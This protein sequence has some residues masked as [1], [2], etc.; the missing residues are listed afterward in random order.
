[1]GEKKK[2]WAE[3]GREKKSAHNFFLK[4]MG[5]KKNKKTWADHGRN[6]LE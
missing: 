5:N 1:M 3:D 4:K 2:T 6:I